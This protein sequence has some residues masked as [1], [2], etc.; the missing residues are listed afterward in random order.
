MTVT[1]NTATDVAAGGY[2]G[3][4]TVANVGTKWPS[5]L[6][7]YMP[8]NV[9]TCSAWTGWSSATWTWKRPGATATEALPSWITV[10]D[11]NADD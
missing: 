7:C 1:A 8:T 4:F 10:T 2:N 5:V 6:A 3:I 11:A 9:R